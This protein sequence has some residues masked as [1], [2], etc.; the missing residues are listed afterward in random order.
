MDRLK[1]L[2]NLTTA[3]DV[4]GHLTLQ[5]R[6]MMGDV[7]SHLQPGQ[8]FITTGQVSSG[9]RLRFG[10]DTFTVGLIERNLSGSFVALLAKET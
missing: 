8:R 4:T 3:Q 6:G 1:I 2:Q 5:R 7:Y 10:L 9:D